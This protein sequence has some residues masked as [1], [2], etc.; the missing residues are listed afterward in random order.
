MDEFSQESLVAEFRTFLQEYQ[1]EKQG[2]VSVGQEEDVTGDLVQLYLAL[3]GL[4]NEVRIESR[5]FKEAL[6]RFRTLFEIIESGRV[7][8]AQELDRRHELWEAQAHKSMSSMFLE[9]LALR[10]RLEQSAIMIENHQPSFLARMSKH[11][12]TWLAGIAE[13]QRMLLRRLEQILF[14]Q[15]ISSIRTLDGPLD[16][17]TMR[18]I[19]V[20]SHADKES[21]IVVAEVLKGYLWHGHLLRA[22]EVRTNKKEENNS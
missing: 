9:F 5:Q 11:E 21:G 16:P 1:A 17:H 4:K 10:D 18:V 22:A 20:E 12:S 13:G 19:G 15:G 2:D 8:L 3:T 7:E 14:G 6:D